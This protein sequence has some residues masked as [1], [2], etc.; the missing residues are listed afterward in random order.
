MV[1]FDVI[2]E[3]S[4][5]IGPFYNTVCRCIDWCSRLYGDVLSLVEAPYVIN[6][7]DPVSI[8]RVQISAANRT[9]TAMSR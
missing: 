4:C 2:S 6:R 7:I 1:N 5:V 8:G 9:R 3:A